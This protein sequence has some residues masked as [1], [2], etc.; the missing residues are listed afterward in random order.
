MR[1]T[2]SAT[3]P[4]FHGPHADGPVARLSASTMRGQ[5]LERA[6]VTDLVGHPLGGGRVVE[7]PSGGGVG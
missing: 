3:S 7:V 2:R 1:S 5:Q 6:P 4:A